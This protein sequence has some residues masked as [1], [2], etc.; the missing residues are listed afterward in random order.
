M[1][2]VATKEVSEHPETW[3]SVAD[4]RNIHPLRA[5]FFGA[6]HLE[7][8]AGK[9]GKLT[10][11][12]QVMRGRPLLKWF[13]RNA[14][15][16]RSAHHVIGA[17]YRQ[18]E[19]L[20]QDAEW[21][22]DNFYIIS[23]AL[24]AIATDL[25]Q[26]YYGQ[27]PKLIDGPLQGFPRVYAMAL[28]LTSHCDSSL[29]EANIT[30]FVQAF[31]TAAP[32]TVGEIWAIPIMLRLCLIENLRR[33]SQHILHFRAYRS[34][35]QTWIGAHLPT[36]RDRPEDHEFGLKDIHC[37]W[38]D[39]YAVHLLEGLHDHEAVHPS[40]VERF[41][42]TLATSGDS[43]LEVRRREKQ[44][45][46]ANQVSI[47]NCVTSLRLLSA[48]DWNKFFESVSHLEVALR[49]DPAGIYPQQ[50]LAT[51]DRYRQVVEELSMHSKTPELEV[52]RILLEHA[53]T[54]IEGISTSPRNHVG[55]FLIDAGR[56]ELEAALGYRPPLADWP[57]RA[58]RAHPGVFYFGGMS[59]LVAAFLAMFAWGT[60]VAGTDALVMALLLAAALVPISELAVSLM[61]YI[62]G[63][64]V[65]PRR[66]PRLGFKDGVPT[67]A[68]TFV[69]IPTM[70]TSRAGAD[71]LVERLE[72]HYLSNPEKNVY[73]ALLTDFADAGTESLP[74]EAA[75]LQATSDGIRALNEKY[76][77]SEP[78][79]FFLLHRRRQWNAVQNCWMGWERKRGKLAEFNRLLR[80]KGDTSFTTISDGFES[81]PAIRFVITLDTDTQL[82]RETARRLIAT[83][84]HPLNQPA[85]DPQQ[86]RVVRGYGILQ[87]RITLSLRGGR[88]SIFARLFTGSAGLDPYTTAV[89]DT[90]QD[91]FGVGSFTGKGIYDVDAFEAAVGA[92]FPDNHILSHDLIEGNYARCGLVTDIELLDDFPWNYQAYARREHRWVRGDWQ[93]MPWLLTQVPAPAEARRANPLPLLERWKIFDNLRRSL[94]PPALLGFLV[95]GWTLMPGAAWLWTALAAAV[96]ATPLLLQLAAIPLQAFRQW[97][98]GQPVHVA[99]RDMVCTAGQIALAAAFL[100]D[101]AIGMIDAV[102]R[103]CYRLWI[104]KRHLMEWESA[105]ATERQLRPGVTPFL[106]SMWTSPVGAALIAGGLAWMHPAALA[107]ALPFLAAWFLAPLIAFVVSQR[108]GS[109]PTVLTAHEQADLRRQARKTWSFFETF[110]TAEDRWLPPDNYQED[111][112]NEIAHRTSPTNIGL[113]LLSCVTA[114]DFGFISLPTLVQRLENTFATLRALERSHG[115]FYNWY[116]TQS[117]QPL[118]PTYLSTVDSGNLAVSLITLKQGLLEKIC[119][120]MFGRPV[121]EGL[122]STVGLLAEN[123]H[124]LKGSRHSRR[125]EIWDQ[126]KSR[127]PELES[128][129]QTAPE[130]LENWPRW[131]DELLQIQADLAEQVRTVESS[132]GEPLLSI[133]RWL[134]SLRELIEARQQEYAH[135]TRG[136]KAAKETDALTLAFLA[137]HKPPQAS[138]NGKPHAQPPEDLMEDSGDNGWALDCL[139]RIQVL[140]AEA[141]ALSNEMD[142]NV[143][144]NRDRHLFAVGYN[145]SLG[146]L[147]T[148]HYDLLASEASLTSF[149]AVARGDVPKK[150]WFQLGRLL[151]RAAQ[152]RVLL[153]WGGTMFEYL[154]PRLFLRV[155]PETLLDDSETAAVLAQIEYGRQCHAPWGISESAF[156]TVDSQLNYQ[157]Q[158]FGVPALGLKRGLSRDLVVAPYATG[159]ALTVLPREALDNLHRLRKE[160]ADGAFGWYEAIDYTAERLP[161]GKRSVVVKCFM[162]HHQGMFF[163]AMA[164]CL[165]NNPLPRRFH[166]EPMVRAT[167]LLLQERVPTA[168]PLAE[169]Q[170]QEAAA[171]PSFHEVP[172]HMSR[173]VTTPHTAQPRTHLL[174][175]AKYSLLVTS[176]GAGYSTSRGLAVTRWREDRTCD[177]HGQFF[178]LRDARTGKRWSAGYQPLCVEPDEYEVTFATDKAEFRRVD[179]G[180]ETRMDITI[181][182]DNHAEVRRLTFTNHDKNSHYLELTSYLEVVLSAQG[183]DLAHPAFGKLFLETEYLPAAEALLCRRRP[184][185]A[186]Q[187]PIWCVHVMATEGRRF[188]AAQ[189]E[190][191][192]ARF[193]GR[194]RTPANPAAL[195]DGAGPLSG[196]TGA[197]LDPILSLRRTFRVKAGSSVQFTFTT[198]LADSREEAL[199]L[200]DYYHDFHG[201]H[202]A[203]ELA[204]AHAQ[205]ELRQLHLTAA[206]THL[207]QRLAA[208]LIFAGPALRAA[209][210]LVAGNRQGQSD[211][212]REG[213]SGDLP[214]LLVRIGAAD[215]MPLIRQIVAAHFFWRLKG[216]AVDLVI[217]NDQEG[218]YF[219]ELQQE[220]QIVLRS[221]EDRT[222]VDKPGGVFLRKASHLSREDQVLLQATA[223]C[224]LVA[225]RGTLGTQL[226]RLERAL[227]APRRAAGPAP[228]QA[229][230]QANVTAPKAAAPL[231]FENGIGGFTNEGEEYVLK[232]RATEKGPHVLPPQPWVNVVA[233]ASFGFMISE[234]GGGFTWAGN[235]QLNRLTPWRND[236]VSDVPGEV[237]YLRDET[238]KEVWSA[239]PLPC[240]DADFTVR[241]GQGYSIFE[242]Q[243]GDTSCELAMFVS[244]NEP[245]K[246]FRVRLRNLSARTRRLSVFF[247]AELVLG[248]VRERMA[249]HLVTEIDSATG[250]LF[251][252]T[253][254]DTDYKSQVV[255]A[256]VNQRPRSWTG[257]RT[258]FLGRHGALTAPAACGQD[259]LSGKVGACLDP[260][261]A[262]QTSVSLGPKEEKEI[263]II[264]GAAAG[265]EE[266]QR[267]ARI[268][269]D[270]ATVQNAW[271]AT[272]KLWSRVAGAVTIRTP[273]A[274]LDMLV[275]RWLPYQVL[276]CR[277]WGRSALYQSGGAYGFRDQLQDSLALVY[278]VPEE[279]R[280]HLLRAASRQFTEGDVQHWWHPPQGAGVRTRFSDDY[281]WLPFAVHH[282]VTTT[283]DRGV[284]DEKIPYLR[285]PALR[286]DQE[287]DYRVPEIAAEVGT[288]WEH[289]LKAI[290]HGLRF[291]AHG[292]PLIGTGDWND[293]MNR[294]GNEGRGES[295]WTGWFLLSILRAFAE[296]CAE[297][298]DPQHAESF[299][300]E[301]ERLHSNL[302]MYAWDGEWYRR[303]YFDDGQPLGAAANDE[304][305]IDSL[306]QSWAVLSGGAVPKRARQAMEAVDKYLVRRDD[307]LVL[308]FTPPFDK[309][310][311]QPGYIKGYVPG[312]RENGGQ[313]THA[314]LWVAQAWALLG[315]AD[316]AAEILDMV[317][318]ISHSSSPEAVE[319]YRLEPYVVAADIYSE[320]HTGRG[321][322]SWY[323]GSASWFYRVVVET[324]LGFELR[325]DHFRLR[326]RLPAGWPLVEFTYRFR[327]ASYVVKLE[328]SK[329]KPTGATLDGQ[330]WEEAD[331]PL[332]DDGKS[333]TVT[334]IIKNDTR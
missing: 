254:W 114:H 12:A 172:P 80:H 294:V 191:D 253:A 91:L 304:C 107:A 316:R 212:W 75:Y 192:R 285:A 272:E 292:L 87:P 327:T 11:S 111:P 218:G 18:K 108:R 243:R 58:I 74:D 160:G 179:A 23:D 130:K 297:R 258:E 3:A 161:Q 6:E 185:T 100:V 7:D 5:E 96:L 315:D 314:A 25:P 318:P 251:A 224:V 9:L 239:T 170:L 331:F 255:F 112:K 82:P 26:G 42:K 156:S 264:L 38:R 250:A 196:T 241:H 155:E 305:R 281:L 293:G 48:L 137:A 83:L 104:S 139:N 35:A 140:A 67:D 128:L 34:Q 72:I 162:A 289:C 86:Q 190:T 182:P 43:S 290:E 233:N 8:H 129:V 95:L 200:A 223:R 51:R 28:E 76:C 123:I 287:E 280:A 276:S 328:R 186:D 88:Q 257:D 215:E 267:L 1:S 22:L 84:G 306:P 319:R 85:F 63:L 135:I 166:T 21:L 122:R 103:T 31:Q 291:G 105:A 141:D 53:Q 309:G 323:T 320:A 163:L 167:E 152:R 259:R 89:S 329:E 44:R 165:L 13:M 120:P 148:A 219:E 301:A 136:G 47:G 174:A 271:E 39:C 145:L 312:I 193:L 65:P 213:V 245:I 184:R 132:I 177:A 57:R 55:Y 217:L 207:F 313:Y 73:F 146:R 41:E 17:A 19:V 277:M 283:G 249:P 52:A 244:P 102:C 20:G 126:I 144:Y 330:P 298:G 334:L 180:I 232:V 101:Q 29:D 94:V 288:L 263:V 70:L 113:Y 183:A 98:K 322:W 62:A 197:V 226:E 127:L 32:L 176:A 202:R 171:L 203:F 194:G 56:A 209:P 14:K 234:G 211:L 282:Y 159:L 175:S 173:R 275:N 121:L 109:V 49:Q 198:A 248:N 24:A 36:L 66:L 157:Y 256:D 151:T 199:A 195:D 64:A 201:V 216:L 46:A 273:D 117:L 33:L 124:A 310:P 143:L 97:R 261:A 168:A 230:Y 142:F 138:S 236:P 238:S 118:H 188:G 227:P 274:A 133:A 221:S 119:T 106:R 71:A 147:D 266:A 240:G 231:R 279:T 260:C 210:T 324:I 303:A 78:P 302:E 325:G 235:S 214:I 30:R 204:W 169:P 189:F 27:L 68:A 228:K 45:Q 15:M 79:R 208:H 110:V 317:N 311:L 300:D 10:E 40:G 206:E 164:N 50:D 77:P 222:L 286:P 237:V 54:A 326:P 229:S 265:V 242:H 307:R 81:V 16:I 92:V 99:G 116:D 149:L 247:Y 125:L 205:V 59:L 262:L 187:K 332:K 252:H 158:A 153:S 299:R 90:Y 37:D 154:M 61:N 115:H 93:I 150:H 284:L 60:V 308:L 4:E 69:V 2:S 278:S 270:A 220:L 134:Q 178:Y 268:C 295:V 321:G 269:Q 225:G 131:L 333:H 246:L 181:S 296:R